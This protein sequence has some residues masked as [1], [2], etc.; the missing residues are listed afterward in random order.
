MALGRWVIK[1]SALAWDMP[2]LAKCFTTLFITLILFTT[3]LNAEQEDDDIWDVEGG[4]SIIMEEYT[5]TWC[6]ICA[7]VD[8][9]MPDYTKANGNR[10]IRIAIHDT[11]DDP[12]GTPITDFRLQKYNISLVT[13]SFWFDGD[14]L[15]GGS[16]D[17]TTLHRSLLSA[18]NKR[19]GDTGINL[20]VKHYSGE[21]YIS[22]ILSDWSSELDTKI[23]FMILYNSVNLPLNLAENGVEQHHDVLF[24][25]NEIYLNNS[26][27]WAHPESSWSNILVQNNTI[28]SQFKI[29]SES[30]FDNLKVVVIHEYVDYNENSPST[31]GATSLSLGG[32]Y[33]LSKI[34]LYL[35][36]M[37]ILLISIIPIIIQ[38]RR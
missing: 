38:S 15:A 24:A 4:Y 2:R 22:S 29:P 6:E 13:P 34:D 20:R 3:P 37:I 1:G 27:N 12:M 23:T 25:Y 36:I 7:S 14:M 11:F 17:T 31:L 18:E 30:Y 28:S 5:A 10:V 9:W 21:L 19:Q 16:P 33:Q 32:D 35:P 8:S 26:S